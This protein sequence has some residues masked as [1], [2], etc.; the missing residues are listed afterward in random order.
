VGPTAV[1]REGDLVIVATTQAH[2]DGVAVG[3]GNIWSG[4]YTLPDGTE[5]TG[6]S[7]GLWIGGA[8]AVRVGPG[9][10]VQIGPARWEVIAVES[11]GGGQV[12][13]RRAPP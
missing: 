4:A 2:V 7:A 3:A 5:R 1:P 6:L 11:T 8:N 9:S 10:V 13:L 12:R